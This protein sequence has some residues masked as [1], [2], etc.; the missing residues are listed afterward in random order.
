MKEETHHITAG[1]R[2]E[3]TAG[4]KVVH[5]AEH[6]ASLTAATAVHKAANDVDATPGGRVGGAKKSHAADEHTGS[7]NAH[8]VPYPLFLY[9][10]NMRV[11]CVGGGRCA[12]RKVASL[13][14]YGATVTVIAP[15]V[16]TR[17]REFA[18]EGSV[19][20]VE[21]AYLPGDL[22]GATLVVGAT[23]DT[24][25]NHEVFLE[26]TRHHQIVNVVDDPANCNAILPSVLRRGDFQV[27]VSTAGAA[28][29]VA[30]QVRRE[31]EARFPAWYGD[32]IDLLGEVRALIKERV[33]GETSRRSGLY[34]AVYA[35][36]LEERI[37][38]GER[39]SASEVYAEVV[40]PLLQEK[41]M[42]Q[43]FPGVSYHGRGE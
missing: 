16:T 5:T 12:E 11:V 38:R 27:A 4:K 26:A 33:P 9:L 42:A 8:T 21:R 3:A 29:G 28:P 34:E 36:G 37:S 25:V 23:N 32:Y 20:L 24:Q 43:N 40:A 35:C 31:L 19:R 2:V 6:A 14:S 18:A 15:E 7:D 22:E 13:V 41:N 39:P 1:R 10:G 17:V 30:R